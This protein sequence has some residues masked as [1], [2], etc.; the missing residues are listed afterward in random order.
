MALN[1]SDLPNSISELIKNA[2][3]EAKLGG[4]GFFFGEPI[5]VPELT[6]MPPDW[7]LGNM[8]EPNAWKAF[9]LIYL[10]TYSPLSDFID[11]G[12]PENPQTLIE[13]LKSDEGDVDTGTWV[14]VFGVEGFEDLY[15]AWKLERSDL[16]EYKFFL[17]GILSEHQQLFDYLL[18]SQKAIINSPSITWN[19]DII[20]DLFK[21]LKVRC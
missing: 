13:L 7:Y 16:W 14:D 4:D 3:N 2:F 11:E 18:T 21:G 5:Y 8:N 6:G 1:I 15:L 17:L 20:W 9:P 12:K 19:E 10:E